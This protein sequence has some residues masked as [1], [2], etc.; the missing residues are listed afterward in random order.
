MKERG[1]FSCAQCVVKVFF[2]ICNIPVQKKGGCDDSRSHFGKCISNEKK[3]SQKKESGGAG[4]ER[5]DT[6]VERKKKKKKNGLRDTESSS[7][8][9]FSLI[10]LPPSPSRCCTV[11][12]FRFLK[13]QLFSPPQVPCCPVSTVLQSPH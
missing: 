8:L 11:V 1:S 3:A 6:N 12:L 9:S 7:S 13:G 4:D 10:T 5:G 2:L